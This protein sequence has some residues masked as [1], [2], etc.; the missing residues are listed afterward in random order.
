MDHTPIM[1]PYIRNITSDHSPTPIHTTTE[2]TTSEGMP[3]AVLPAT[4]A[5][6][7]ALQPLDTPAM[8]TTGIV[9]PHPTLAIYPSG[10]T[11]TTQKTGAAFASAAP[12]MQHKT[13]ILGR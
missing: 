11:H 7:T 5:A 10:A 8:I 4:A 2:A 6:Y 13:L 3:H 12:T 1:V 9:T